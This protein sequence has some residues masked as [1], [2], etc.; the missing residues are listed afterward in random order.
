VSKPPRITH[1][2]GHFQGVNDMSG[3]KLNVAARADASV[4]RGAGMGERTRVIGRYN[5]VC[6]DREG[7]EKWRDHID[8]VVVTEGKNLMLDAAFTASAYTAIGPFVGLISSQSWSATTV[9]D[10]QSSHSGWVEA[11]A[12]N[13][14]TYDGG[15]VTASWAAASG[16]SKAFSANA[17]F[18]I[19][20]TGTVKGCFLV[21]GT[22]AVSSIANTAGK[23]LSAGTFSGGDKAVNSGDTLNVTYSIAL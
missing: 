21:F 5:V 7:R 11:G 6:V 22:G 2:R 23:L 15:R 1:G 16:G 3:E 18:S 20:G 14:P 4:V 8:N 9:T 12:A 10:T 13:A 19:T 17:A